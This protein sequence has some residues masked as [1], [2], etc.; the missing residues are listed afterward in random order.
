[1]CVLSILSLQ[2]PSGTQ[3]PWKFSFSFQTCLYS[4]V[5]SSF[6]LYS[7]CFLFSFYFKVISLLSLDSH[8]TC[9][10]LFSS[11]MLCTCPSSFSFPIL[12]SPATSHELRD[13]PLNAMAITTY[14][15]ASV[16]P[17]LA[18]KMTF[19]RVF[20]IEADRSDPDNATS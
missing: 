20:P 3:V 18:W 9:I 1:M 10:V 17:T 8:S 6:H 5:P 15:V 11:V 14:L 19:S 2:N 4:P 12:C 13:Y 16:T 7:F